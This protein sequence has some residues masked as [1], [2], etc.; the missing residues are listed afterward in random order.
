TAAFGG[1]VNCTSLSRS[2]LIRKAGATS[3]LAALTVAAVS[4]VV[5]VADPS[6]LGYVPKFVLAGLLFYLGSDMVYQWLLHSSRRLL[7]L[8]YLS[9][10]AIAALI[11]Y[12][13][14]IAGVL[15]GVVIGCATFALSASRVNAIKFT[16]DG[17]E[18]RSSLDRGSDELSLLAGHGQEIQGMTLQ[19]Y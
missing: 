5:L 14:F 2:I 8:E 19:S 13:G 15:I 17:S 10:I 18:F 9:L 4:A 12:S 3:R 1:Y 7:P 11:I 16:F 6:F